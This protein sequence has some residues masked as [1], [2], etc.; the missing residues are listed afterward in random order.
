MLGWAIL[1]VILINGIFSFWQE[2]RAEKAL[3]ALENL[4]PRQV[5]A[6]RSGIIEQIP[7]VE[8]VPGDILILAGRRRHPRRL[9]TGRGFVCASTTPR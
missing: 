3:A 4:L 7:A 1:G 5:M 6:R 9:P 8:L 2:Y